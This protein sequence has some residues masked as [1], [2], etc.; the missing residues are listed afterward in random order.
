MSAASLRKTKT[1][2]AL[3]GLYAINPVNDEKI[4]IWTSDYVLMG[5]G[6]GAIMA[7]PAHD[8][9]DYAF[10]KTFDLPIIEVVAGGDITTEAY[11][12]CEH[13]KLVNSGFLNGMEVS[14]AIPAIIDFLVKK[15]SVSAR[16]TINCATGSSPVSVIGANPFRWYTANTAAGCRFL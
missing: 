10:A 16:L 12:E 3:S 2:V 9:R 14:E 1:G 13:G 8:E 4:P 5:Y 6:T 15:A 11:T 7:V